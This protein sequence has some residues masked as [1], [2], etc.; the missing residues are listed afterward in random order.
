MADFDFSKSDIELLKEFLTY[1]NDFRYPV[2]TI[3][4]SPEDIDP[5]TKYGGEW[6]K[7]EDRFLWATGE[8]TS[9]TYTKDGKTVTKSLTAGSVGGEIEH[10]LTTDEMP[11]HS[12]KGW[13]GSDL[14]QD[15]NACFMGYNNYQYRQEEAEV[16]G[17][18]PHNNMP[19]YKAMYMWIK[20]KTQKQKELE[21]SV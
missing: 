20:T 19:P 13:V 2:G 18:Q 8:T 4:T 15:A 14:A 1:P 10:T 17:S 7:I 6:E 11:K 21:E 9:I 12:H 16:G 5:A 3:L